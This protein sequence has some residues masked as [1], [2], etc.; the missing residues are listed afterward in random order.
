M[1]EKFEKL[2]RDI[3][4]TI[5]V[6]DFCKL[7]DRDI[8]V[9]QHVEES[10]DKLISSDKMSRLSKERVYS[11]YIRCKEYYLPNYATY[12]LVYGTSKFGKDFLD[13]FDASVSEDWEW[14]YRKYRYFRLNTG[15]SK[16]VINSSN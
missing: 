12:L 8:K 15:S 10:L 5:S 7:S 3:V 1:E 14:R 9:R 4:W 6:D 11:A 16:K 13:L 2:K